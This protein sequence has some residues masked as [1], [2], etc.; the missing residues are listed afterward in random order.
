M[1]KQV[2]ILVRVGESVRFPGRCVQHMTEA[3]GT[4]PVRHRVARRTRFVEVPVCAECQAALAQRS[5]AEE[6]AI[7]LSWI[8][9][10]IAGILGAL[11]VWFLVPIPLMTALRLVVALG[12]GAA[13]AAV[14]WTW[15]RRNLDAKA[16]PEKQTVLQSVRIVHFSWR[17][18]TFE[19]ANEAYAEAFTALNKKQLMPL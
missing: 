3:A 4:M 10:A 12:L 1:S 9:T 17:A 5:G 2:K 11:A 18:M 8:A 15:T 16:R 7:R 14:A 13:L 19:F 6:R